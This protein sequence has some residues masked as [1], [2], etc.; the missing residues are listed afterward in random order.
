LV[1]TTPSRNLYELN[2]TKT[3]AVLLETAYHDNREDAEWIIS[4]LNLIARALVLS[5]TQYFGIPFV[6]PNT[7]QRGVIDTESFPVNIR[8]GPSFE[9]PSLIVVPN[10]AGVIITGTAEN[11]YIVDY[12]GTIGYVNQAYITLV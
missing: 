7:V 10:G 1:G 6:E 12:M 3:T 4:N 9:A 2:N 8:S 11:W 5:L